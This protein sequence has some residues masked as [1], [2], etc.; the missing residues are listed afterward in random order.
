MLVLFKNVSA[1][2]NFGLCVGF[3]EPPGGWRL[4]CSVF[5]DNG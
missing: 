2:C 4:F 3:T 1:F 5:D